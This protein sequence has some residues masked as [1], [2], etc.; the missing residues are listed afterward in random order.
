MT[1]FGRAGSTVCRM[2]A[3]S[4]FL[5]ITIYMYHREHGLPHFHAVYAGDGISVEV[6]S[7]IVRGS[8]P[9]RALRHVLEWAALHEAELLAN[10]ELARQ[11]KPIRRI[12]P[13]E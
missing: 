4:R 1:V 9:G 2:P 3:I 11:D 6:E 7:R 5:G 10:W 8:F 12:A 13:L